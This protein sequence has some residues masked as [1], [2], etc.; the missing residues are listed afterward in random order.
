MEISR[1]ITFLGDNTAVISGH[2]AATN[3]LKRYNYQT[4]AE[5]SCMDLPP[6]AHGL[7]EMKL[8]EK[9]ALVISHR[10]LC[11]FV[12]LFVSGKLFEGATDIPVLDFR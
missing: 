4:G 3:K 2:E 10:L 12:C 1:S 9:L 7:A 5:L 6:D 8:G 11:L